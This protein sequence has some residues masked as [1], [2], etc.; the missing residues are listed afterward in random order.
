MTPETNFSLWCI[1]I[2]LICVIFS[3]LDMNRREALKIK[4]GKLKHQG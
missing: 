1:F 2:S 4:K 3:N